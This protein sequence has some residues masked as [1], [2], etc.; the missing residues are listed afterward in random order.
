MERN[1][2]LLML[3]AGIALHEPLGAQDVEGCATKVSVGASTPL[4]TLVSKAKAL[5]LRKDEYETT[6]AFEARATKAGS[7]TFSSPLTILWAQPR[8]TKFDA[9]RGVVMVERYTVNTTCAMYRF[10]L[11]VEFSNVHIGPEGKYDWQ[12]QDRPYCI[13]RPAG[14]TDAGSYTASN[15][16]GA[17]AN[18]RSVKDTEQGI[19]LGTGLIGL[20]YFPKPDPTS[21]AKDPWLEA[22]AT[23]AEAKSLA[24][25]AALIIT[26]KPRAPYFATG[27]YYAGATISSPTSVTT[28]LDMVIG[29]PTC[30][31]L[32]DRVSG[33]VFAQREFEFGQRN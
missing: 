21:D 27:H 11:P 17:T 20:D 25:N 32:V 12:K 29:I 1:R 28:N 22:P 6:A 23:V 4:S 3:A 14:R 8:L 16:Y 33:K 2:I 9:D 30:V 18:V 24:T 15:A 5:R 13:T 26:V 10:E 7:A 31:T 19:Y